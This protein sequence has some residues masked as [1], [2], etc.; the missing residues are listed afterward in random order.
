MSSLGQ[1]VTNSKESTWLDQSRCG[2]F[3]DLQAKKFE[4]KRSDKHRVSEIVPHKVV[5]S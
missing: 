5:Q 2:I 4:T 3:S 1:S